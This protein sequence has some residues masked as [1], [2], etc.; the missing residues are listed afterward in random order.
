MG[1][2]S[3]TEIDALLSW[4]LKSVFPVIGS[5]FLQNSIDAENTQMS[6]APCAK[7][8]GFGRSEGS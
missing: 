7:E 3:A 6:T 8:R 1:W 5:F 2:I 4:Y